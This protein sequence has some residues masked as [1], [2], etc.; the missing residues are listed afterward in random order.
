MNI[1]FNS[2]YGNFKTSIKAVVPDGSN[3][4]ICEEGLAN[5]LYRVCGSSVD[6]GF[7]LKKGDKR[8]GIPYSAENAA[9]VEKLVREKIEELCGMGEDPG[10]DA[11]EYMALALEFKITGQHEAG[12]AGSAMVRATALVDAMLGDEKMEEAYRTIFGLQGLADADNATREQL[13]EFAHSKG[14]GVQPPKRK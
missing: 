14:L 12:E 1:E 11:A 7:G 10:E 5:I 2:N 4:V 6:K 8:T 13:I 3:R 9:K